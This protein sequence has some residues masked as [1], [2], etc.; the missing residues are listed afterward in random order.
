LFIRP[1]V[2]LKQTGVK[3]KYCLIL[4]QF[5]FDARNMSL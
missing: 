4:D 5:I 2:F 3:D 1:P